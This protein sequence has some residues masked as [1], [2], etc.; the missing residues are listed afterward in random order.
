MFKNKAKFLLALYLFGI[1]SC[2]PKTEDTEGKEILV[3]AAASLTDVL[4]ELA[5]SYT[6]DMGVTVTFSFA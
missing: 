6:N 2:N 5:A 1:V 3:L 4:N